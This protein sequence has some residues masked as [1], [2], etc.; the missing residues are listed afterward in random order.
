MQ[1]NETIEPFTIVEKSS[2]G[3]NLDAEGQVF[4]HSF[5][6]AYANFDPKN[7]LQLEPGIDLQKFLSD[8]FRDEKER[9]SKPESPNIKE[10]YL[11]AR[12]KDGKCIG[13]A[14]VQVK[15]E[16]DGD[17][18]YIHQLAVLPSFQR[19]GVGK[20]LVFHCVTPKTRRI[21]I[22]IRRIN[23][24]AKVFYKKLGFKES[25]PDNNEAHAHLDPKLYMLLSWISEPK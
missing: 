7:D 17:Q 19:K 12:S 1:P 25:A 11:S 15:S 23:N 6:M 14:S 8:A 2:P 13:Y 9:F 24:E 20:E 10:H 4:F 5:E 18:L 22:L 21:D 3:G 16:S